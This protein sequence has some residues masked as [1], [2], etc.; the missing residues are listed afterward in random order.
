MKVIVQ[1]IVIVLVSSR[2]RLIKLSKKFENLTFFL[3]HT[4]EQ[5]IIG[6]VVRC[7]R[8]SFK[9]IP[10]GIPAETTELYLDSNNISVIQVDRIKHL[11]SLSRLDLSNNRISILSNF[12][13]SDLTKLSTL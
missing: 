8:N 2:R 13:F 9:E 4:N 1:Q 11:K 3:L 7:S 12:T 5:S 6:T 10:K